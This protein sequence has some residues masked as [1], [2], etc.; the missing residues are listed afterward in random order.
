ML[1]WRERRAPLN[2]RVMPRPTPA[3]A[4]ALNLLAIGDV[5]V[6]QIESALVRTLELHSIAAIIFCFV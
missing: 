1:G 2:R 4:P 6:V 5:S 3:L